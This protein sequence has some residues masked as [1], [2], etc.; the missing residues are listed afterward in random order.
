MLNLMVLVA[1]T[2]PG[3]VG[4]SVGTWFAECARTHGRF[5]VVVADLAE[6]QLPLMD[7]A[8]HPRL[9]RYSHQHTKDWSDRVSSANASVFVMPEYNA[10]YAAPLKNAI[11]YLVQ[12]WFYMPVGLLAYGGMS[13]GGRAVQAIR[14]VLSNMSMVP[15]GRTVLVP[16]VADRIRDGVFTPSDHTEQATSGML[17]ELGTLADAL[18]PLRAA[19]LGAWTDARGAAGAS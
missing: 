13:G 2:R 8:A 5:D 3:R 12:E 4:G 6:M 9:G 1:S 16:G 11:D 17:D 7:E 15:S 14:P 18:R 10:G 19:H